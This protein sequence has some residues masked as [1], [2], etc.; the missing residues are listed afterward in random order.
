MRLS[1]QVFILVAALASST[2]IPAAQV[3]T[4]ERAQARR[5]LLEASRL[6]D[7]VPESQRSSAVANIASQLAHSGDLEDALRVS[8]SQK[9]PGDQDLATG[10]IAWNLVQQGNVGQ[11][12]RLVESISNEQNRE[13]QYAPLAAL[14]AEKGD[15]TGALRIVQIIREPQ[16][17]VSI[18][19]QIAQ[20]KARSKNRDVAGATEVLHQAMEIAEE[21]VHENASNANLLSEIAATQSEIGDT[22]GAL[23]TLGELSAIAHQYAGPE[24][25]GLLLH[26]LGCAQAQAGDLVGALQ[27]HEDMVLRSNSG[28]NSDI[29]LMT[30]AEEQAK[31][32]LMADAL[33][34]AD[35]ISDNNL[36]SATLRQV[37]IARGTNRTLQDA[38]EA[39]H[40]IP[41]SASRSE[42]IGALALEQ[43]V[44]G[45]PAAA[46]TAE[47]ALEFAN[48][49]GSGS[50]SSDRGR[51]MIAV[52]RAIFGD[53]AGAE[54]IIKSMPEPE[55]RVWPLWNLTSM[56][57]EAGRETE[58]L[59]LAEDEN[60]P[61]PKLHAL[62]GT[63]QGLLTRVASKER[64]SASK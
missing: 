34:S 45:N 1:F 57:T 52:T 62:L 37:A 49:A 7:E 59:T 14:L 21:L 36:R 4:S 29:V 24:G 32:G 17:R 40:R 63:A 13:R 31:Q 22:T 51:E 43:A 30:I 20:Q 39:I 19:V 18:L 33:Q 44:A 54:E 25:N 10:L 41:N 50:V 2:E 26:L 64:T 48:E 58:A 38:M 16:G 28:S 3:E 8:Q 35:R 15:L 56:L 9:N 5:L 60:A 6:I 46:L 47:R 61:L 55:S 42:A 23:R 11:A 53:F 27:T 12:L